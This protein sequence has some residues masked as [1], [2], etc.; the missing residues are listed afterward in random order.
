MDLQLTD[1][2]QCSNCPQT[3]HMLL[4]WLTPHIPHTERRLQSPR[5][6]HAQ[7]DSKRNWSPRPHPGEGTTTFIPERPLIYT[8]PRAI[9]GSLAG[10]P[11][12][13]GPNKRETTRTTKSRPPWPPRGE[14]PN[15]HPAAAEGDHH[16]AY[17][18]N[19]SK[20]GPPPIATP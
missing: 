3:P 15:R 2:L 8:T 11:S 17:D 13:E 5:I 10:A 7:V 1:R 14:R 4:P 16:T 18:N 6:R 9:P 12:K 19:P 20:Y